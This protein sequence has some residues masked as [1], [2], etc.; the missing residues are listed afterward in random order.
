M[1]TPLA[2]LEQKEKSKERE[3]FKL[4]SYKIN[5]YLRFWIIY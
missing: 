3:F 2:E 1:T 4:F 5:Y